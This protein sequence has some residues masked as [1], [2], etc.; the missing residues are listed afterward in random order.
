MK[1][2]YEA[3]LLL[4][5]VVGYAVGA[6]VERRLGHSFEGIYE[7]KGIPAVSALWSTSRW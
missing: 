6:S 4:L 1:S 5:C 3:V 7:G 2:P